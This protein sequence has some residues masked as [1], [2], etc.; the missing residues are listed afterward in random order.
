VARVSVPLVHV[1]TLG[2]RKLHA[3]PASQETASL[4]STYTVVKRQASGLIH[5]YPVAMLLQPFLKKILVHVYTV[6]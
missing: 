2:R 5:A 1:Y 4:E 3:I 6:A